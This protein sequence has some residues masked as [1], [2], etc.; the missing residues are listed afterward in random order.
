MLLILCLKELQS[1]S[2]L[3]ALGTIP[4][5]FASICL[6]LLKMASSEEKFITVPFR[7]PRD[8]IFNT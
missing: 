3:V 2:I 5:K 8:L 7:N 6:T 1:L 4:K